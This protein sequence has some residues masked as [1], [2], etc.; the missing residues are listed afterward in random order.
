M[1]I[2]RGS[3]SQHGYLVDAFRADGPVPVGLTKPNVEI[4]FLRDPD[5]P[6]HSRL[7]LHLRALPVPGMGTARGF[8][9]DFSAVANAVSPGVDERLDARL[10]RFVA[11]DSVVG[12]SFR[13]CRR[14]QSGFGRNRIS[15]SDFRF[16]SVCAPLAPVLVSNW[17]FAKLS[18]KPEII[19]F[20]ILGEAAPTMTSGKKRDFGKSL[21]RLPD[22]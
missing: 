3:V 9:S 13:S 17:R 2:Y 8:V 19:Y 10:R 12:L 7:P 6:L 18:S 11:D 1:V 15:W 22:C 20:L 14:S 5:V 4:F 16:R 21:L